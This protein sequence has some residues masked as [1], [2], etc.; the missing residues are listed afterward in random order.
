MGIFVSFA[1]LIYGLWYFSSNLF[2]LIVSPRLENAVIPLIPGVTINFLDFITYLILPVLFVLTFHELGHGVAA[3]A[4]K[5]EVKSTGVFAAGAFFLVGFGA[6]VEPNEQKYRSRH[7][8]RLAKM[9]IASAGPFVNIIEIGIAFLLILNFPGLI[10][11]GYS[12]RYFSIQHVST[13]AEGGFNENN[14]VAGEVCVAINDTAVNLDLNP[15]QLNDILTNKTELRCEPNDT[16][17]FHL[18][19]PTTKT[20]VNRTVVLGPRNFLGFA[21]EKVNNSAVRISTVYALEQGGNNDDKLEENWIVT[22]LNEINLDYANNITIEYLTTQLQAGTKVN[23]TIE[24]KSKVE[25]N[26]NYAPN[27]PGAFLFNSTYLGFTYNYTS[28]T[29]VKITRVYRNISESGVNEGN[30]PENILITKVNGYQ[31]NRQTNPLATIIDTIIRPAPTSIL[32]F[33]TSDERNYYVIAKEIPVISIYI[34]L[35]PADYWIPKN[36]FSELLGPT[37][38]TWLEKEF[39]I[40]LM[41][42]FFVVILNMIP[43]PIFD[44]NRVVKEIID[45]GVE[46]RRGQRYQRRKRE[47]V[48]MQ[49]HEKDLEYNFPETEVLAVERV[50]SESDPKI[51]FENGKD[52]KLLQSWQSDTYDGM[53][54]DVPGGKKP[55]DQENLLVD[56]VHSHDENQRL[57]KNILRVIWIVALVIVIANFVLSF[58]NYGDLI[59]GS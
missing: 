11:L 18:Y 7:F 28:D 3:T 45:W 6:F 50:A 54:F 57:K 59:F 32:T 38:P 5:L 43:A 58:V 30:I 56:Y 27:A 26:V 24:G 10:S 33:T 51:I 47:G 29:T 25:I 31:I 12:P 52:F 36:F 21:N 37:F 20:Y 2:S 8:P 46:K 35:V 42:A 48:R 23:I 44:G 53:S 17:I 39:N 15:T 13:T 40:F 1:F 22:Q 16:L 19:Q 4:E 55:V 49:F 34:G 14:L 41:I 9:R